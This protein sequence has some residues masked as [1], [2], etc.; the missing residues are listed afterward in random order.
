M[1]PAV[2]KLDDRLLAVLA[3]PTLRAMEGKVVLVAPS[4]S[5]S[6]LGV[7]TRLNQNDKTYEKSKYLCL[8]AILCA[9]MSIDTS[10]SRNASWYDG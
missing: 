3:D 10:R 1:R 7:G 8:D 2:P 5:T 6:F 9:G 4:L